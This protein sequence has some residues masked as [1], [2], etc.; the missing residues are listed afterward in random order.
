MAGLVD[1][2]HHHAVIVMVGAQNQQFRWWEPRTNSSPGRRPEPTV[3]PSGSPQT[4]NSH[5]GSPKPT[6]PLAG[7]PNQQ[8]PGENPEPTV[9]L[10]GAP[11][12]QFQNQ[13]FP[14]WEPRTNSPPDGSLE[15]TVPRVGA[16]NQQSLLWEPRTSGKRSPG[17]NPASIVSLMGAQCQ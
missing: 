17:G 14:W 1:V 6:I 4:N 9:R 8:S 15:P 16:Q 7:A 11:N 3:P 10:V 12:T 5:S 2:L 13:Q